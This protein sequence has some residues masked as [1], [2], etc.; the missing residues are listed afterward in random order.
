MAMLHSSPAV[1]WTRELRKSL[2]TQGLCIARRL[3]LPRETG[4]SATHG[5]EDSDSGVKRLL[6][7]IL[8]PPLTGFMEEHAWCVQHGACP[9]FLPLSLLRVFALSPGL[10][11]AWCESQSRNE[12]RRCKVRAG[13]GRALGLGSKGRAGIVPKD[14]RY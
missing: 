6:A 4:T 10:C 12:A 13:S 2:P 5:G 9:G 8:A 1:Y 11:Y 14:G 7:Q 3:W